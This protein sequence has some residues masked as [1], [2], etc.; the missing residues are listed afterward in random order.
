MTGQDT[1][2]KEMIHV[3]GQMEQDSLRFHQATQK[4]TQFKIYEL[5]ISGIFHLIF[6]DHDGPHVT[7][8]AESETTDKGE[9]LYSVWQESRAMDGRNNQ[10]CFYS[11]KFKKL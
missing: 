1:L 3:P 8:T 7:E 5:F 9:L 4:S 2:D 6:S 10:R 11:R